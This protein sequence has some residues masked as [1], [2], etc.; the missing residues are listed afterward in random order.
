ML[1]RSILW[2]PEDMPGAEHLRL[3]VTGGRIL[4]DGLVIAIFEGTP[5]RVHYVLECDR[6]W[7]LR[8]LE[9]EVAGL[10]TK[11]LVAEADG[12]GKWLVDGKSA[13][14]LA[15]CL[16]PDIS[17]TPFTNT[18]PIRRLG[19]RPGESAEIRVAYVAVPQLTAQPMM[20]RYT[21]VS[22]DGSSAIYRYEAP[23]TGYAT[24]LTVDSDGLVVHYPGAFGRGA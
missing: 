13:P 16:D 6:S 5:Y 18:L 21:C 24:T 7:H 10:G 20:Q 4:A 11:R 17:V 19:L 1:E 3:H 8:N 2:L 14:E 22:G 15:G 9:V 23:D 12:R